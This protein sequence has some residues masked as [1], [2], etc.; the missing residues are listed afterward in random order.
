MRSRRKSLFLG[1][2]NAN[3]HGTTDTTALDSYG[4]SVAL[5]GLKLV[6]GEFEVLS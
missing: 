6:F 1:R 5:E 2:L 4:D 3:T